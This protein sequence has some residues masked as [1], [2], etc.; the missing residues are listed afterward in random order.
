MKPL[1]YLLM[2]A[3]AITFLLAGYYLIE[4]WR[5]TLKSVQVQ[6]EIISFVVKPSQNNIYRAEMLSYPVVRF[7]TVEGKTVVFTSQFGFHPPYHYQPGDQVD[8]LYH[9]HNLEHATLGNFLI[10]WL[11]FGVISIAAVF[12]TLLAYISYPG[13]KTN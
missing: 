9:P 7:E 13:K 5:L 1:S 4:S 10:S 6:G 8:V 2:L 3:S 11:R 12:L